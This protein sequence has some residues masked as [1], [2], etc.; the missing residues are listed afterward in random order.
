MK[1]KI[2]KK[3][4]TKINYSGSAS[5]L[6][7]SSSCSRISKSGS[8]FDSNQ[9]VAGS[10]TADRD[11]DFAKNESDV[12]ILSNPSQSSIEILDYNQQPSRKHS[13]ER[14][15][16]QLPSL[17]T[18]LDDNDRL[19][20][21]MAATTVVN[22]QTSTQDLLKMM[23]NGASKVVD[24]DEKKTLLNLTHLTESS[25]S[26]SVTDSICTAYEQNGS[27]GGSAVDSSH[28][29]SSPERNKQSVSNTSPEK[30]DIKNESV[31]S[32]LGGKQNFYTLQCF[33][34]FL[35]LNDF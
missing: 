9:S 23:E 31:I 35:I 19:Q 5:S 24:S 21:L 17:D 16:S 15:V 10:S 1:K 7:G 28:N 32:M 29:V 14:R 26:G 30:K 3:H 20:M 33:L 2:H 18:I 34:F 25:S 22:Q 12:E 4:S 27:G 13:E 6:N 8:S 11:A